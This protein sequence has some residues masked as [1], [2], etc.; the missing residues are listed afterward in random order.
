[1]ARCRA[2]RRSG[3]LDALSLDAV[4]ALFTLGTL[5]LGALCTLDALGL[6]RKVSPCS[7]RNPVKL[8][9][10]KDSWEL[11]SLLCCDRQSTM[12][13]DEVQA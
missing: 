13:L 5:L 6:L 7:S 10:T 11:V 2:D 1:M 4:S 8:E 3:T 12:W 9:T